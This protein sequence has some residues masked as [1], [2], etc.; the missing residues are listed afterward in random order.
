MTCSNLSTRTSVRIGAMLAAAVIGM[1][2]FTAVTYAD[3]TKADN[4]RSMPAFDTC[5]LE[6]SLI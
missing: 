4:S 3:Q 2:S 5:H 1:T 6:R